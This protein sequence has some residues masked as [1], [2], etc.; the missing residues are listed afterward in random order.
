MQE[1]MCS[2]SFPIFWPIFSYFHIYYA[3]LQMYTNYT[4][5]PMNVNIRI[6][7]S[8]YCSNNTKIGQY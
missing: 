7:V 8:H 1:T 2:S 4:N 3:N 6:L 5:K